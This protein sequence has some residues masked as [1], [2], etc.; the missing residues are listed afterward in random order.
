[1]SV[2]QADLGKFTPSSLV[3]FRALAKSQLMFK[4][5]G[6]FGWTLRLL[7]RLEFVPIKKKKKKKKKN[8]FTFKPVP[9][10]PT[11]I[12]TVH[13]GSPSFFGAF[14]ALPE[15]F[16]SCSLNSFF[17]WVSGSSVEGGL[18][19]STT[20]LMVDSVN[21]MMP[22]TPPIE[23]SHPITLG[24][25][26]TSG[27][28]GTAGGGGNPGGGIAMSSGSGT[29]DGSGDRNGSGLGAACTAAKAARWHHT[30]N[31]V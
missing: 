31:K 9:S 25:A 11:W 15:Y 16:S 4:D 27:G 17:I 23:P 12:P 24:T 20:L 29:G 30:L 1:M 21:E 5:F 18:K 8:R 13:G 14:T 26:G 19:A 3:I 6:E 22:R 10:R 7:C 2:P 28:G